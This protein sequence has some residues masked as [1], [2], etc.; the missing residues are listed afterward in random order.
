M[1]AATMNPNVTIGEHTPMYV[2]KQVV[3]WCKQLLNY[4]KDASGILVSGGSMAN[5][6][7]LT[8]ARNSFLG[9]PFR[10]E[11]LIQINKQLVIYCS[12][13]THS[14]ILKAA[15]ILGI[16]TNNVRKIGVNDSFE[17]DTEALISSIKKDKA[18][19]LTP[20]AV[21]A[22]T[23]TVNTGAIDPLE[24]IYEI[25][26]QFGLWFHIDGAYGALAKLDD[27]YATAL[28]YIEKADSVAFDLHKWLYIPYEVG[29]A[30][31]K[32]SAAHR[33][34]FA[35]TPNYL[36]QTQRGLAGGLDS[37]NNYG[38]ELSRGFKALKVW[39]SLKEH[40]RDKYAQLITQNN[41]QAAYL[42]HKIEQLKSLELVAPV[43]MSIVCYR[44]IDDTLSSSELNQLNEEILLQLQEKGIA[45]P[46]STILNG[47]YCIRV[48]IVNHRTKTVD[49]DLLIEKSL[50]IGQAVFLACFKK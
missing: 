19:G 27:Q 29:C 37:I 42:G 8:V 18:N 7:S 49:L 11:G 1:L 9:L 12:I 38:F 22:T 23:G 24:T 5:I 4:P 41:R 2:D 45:S 15:E 31:I 3:E 26:Q 16:G 30:L 43:S 6:T 10:Q 47:K 40:G 21:V 25:C 34:S 50:E 32:N 35:I 20:F 33:A 17:M 44:F 46:S 48:C 28:K 36:L 39:M 13:E 14:C